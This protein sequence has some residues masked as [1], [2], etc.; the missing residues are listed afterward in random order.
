M[1]MQSTKLN[2]SIRYFSAVLVLKEHRDVQLSCKKYSYITQ[3]N[4]LTTSRLTLTAATSAA[5]LMATAR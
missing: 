4:Y 5:G 2:L 1:V 3:Y